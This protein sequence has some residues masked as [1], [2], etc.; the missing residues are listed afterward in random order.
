MRRGAVPGGTKEAKSQGYVPGRTRFSVAVEGSHPGSDGSLPA[1]AST[2]EP[3]RRA[4]YDFMSK[5]DIAR[6][7]VFCQQRDDEEIFIIRTNNWKTAAEALVHQDPIFPK[8]IQRLDVP[9]T[10]MKL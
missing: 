1:Q 5:E 9:G 7:R 3:E 6:S 4:L 8:G 2:P 10:T